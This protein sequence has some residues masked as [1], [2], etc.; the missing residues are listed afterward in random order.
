MQS[1]DLIT[2]LCK[3]GPGDV[4]DSLHVHFLGG[5]G[6]ANLEG[7]LVNH[8]GGL[9]HILPVIISLQNV[10]GNI[11]VISCEILIRA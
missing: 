3:D 5:F 8:L 11:K 6:V 10:L 9:H 4:L 2:S 1:I 7:G